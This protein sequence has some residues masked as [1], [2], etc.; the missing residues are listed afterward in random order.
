[1]IGFYEACVTQCIEP[2]STAV[3]KFFMMSIRGY[4]RSSVDILFADVSE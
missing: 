4:I 2:A 1:M 3:F